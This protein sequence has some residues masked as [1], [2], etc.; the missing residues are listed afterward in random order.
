MQRT[1]YYLYKNNLKRATD[2]N[3]HFS[4]E[5]IDGY[6]HMKSY[7]TYITREMQAKVRNHCTL[8]QWLYKVTNWE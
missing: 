4:R 1:P 5:E 6:K 8:A 3:R 7:S 2:L